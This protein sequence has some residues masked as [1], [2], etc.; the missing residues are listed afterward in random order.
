ML[1]A[2]ERA[3]IE[4]VWDLIAGHEAPFGAELLLRWVGGESP[5]RR[6]VETGVSG[7]RGGA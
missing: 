1:S 6:E 7:L 4:Q 2:L 5:G 3:H